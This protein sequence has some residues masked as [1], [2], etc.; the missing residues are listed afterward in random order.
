M[1]SLSGQ[2]TGRQFTTCS[3]RCDDMGSF[4]LTITKGETCP[5]VVNR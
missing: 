3:Y 1:C 2:R 5:F 4:S